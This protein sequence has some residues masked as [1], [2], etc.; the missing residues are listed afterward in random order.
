MYI[1]A[2]LLTTTTLFIQSVL[3]PNFTLLAYAPWIALVVL[4]SDMPKCLYLSCLSGVLLDLVTDDPIGVHALNYTLIALFLFRYKK[5]FLFSSP[6]HLSVFTLLVSFGS[7]LL[8]LF[9]LF[10]FDRRVPFTGQWAFGDLFLMPIAD[11]I[12]AFLLIALPLQL[13]GPAGVL[14]LNIKKRLFPTSH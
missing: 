2:F 3:F 4:S 9:L 12:Y 8:Q 10:L 5:Y 7:T 13:L 6:I 1:V 14:W 11:A